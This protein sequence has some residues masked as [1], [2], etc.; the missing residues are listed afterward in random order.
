MS[1]W[2]MYKDDVSRRCR[3]GLCTVC[4]A[5]HGPGERAEDC[6]AAR[7]HF[8]GVTT[9]QPIFTFNIKLRFST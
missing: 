4:E 8:S 3:D 5:R 1:N 9:F 7:V 6:A 2:P